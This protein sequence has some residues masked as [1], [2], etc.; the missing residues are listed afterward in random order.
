[1]ENGGTTFITWFTIAFLFFNKTMKLL[2]GT[3]Y[4]KISTSLPISLLFHDRVSHWKLS[5]MMIAKSKFYSSVSHIVSKSAFSN[6]LYLSSGSQEK[7]LWSRLE[8]Q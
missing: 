6:R 4:G 8:C 1:M 3:V 7:T 2:L 5:R